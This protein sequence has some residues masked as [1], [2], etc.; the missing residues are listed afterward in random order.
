MESNGETVNGGVIMDAQSLVP[1]LEA[2]L[3][4]SPEPLSLAALKRV[5]GEDVPGETIHA[6]LELLKA[7]SMEPGRGV[8]LVEVALG[9]QYLT[10]EE[11]FPFVEKIAKTA[12]EERIT[13]AGIETLSIVAYKQPLTRAEVDAIR[14][15]A[16]GNHIRLLMDRGLVKV[17][18]R[19]EL[20]GA[21][22]L[23]GTTKQFLKHFGL[24]SLEDLPDPKDLGRVI[25]EQLASN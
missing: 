10:R 9:W 17:S 24:R 23:Y 18:G 6:G 15:A 12:K 22:F 3:F 14:G 4:S 7:R 19:A 2:L 8:M 5:F 11:Y 21:P 1:A 20:P 25:S 16:S 13:A